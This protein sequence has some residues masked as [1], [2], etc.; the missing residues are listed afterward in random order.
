MGTCCNLH[1]LVGVAMDEVI[2]QG[3][4]SSLFE[5]EYGCGN[6]RIPSSQSAFLDIVI[7]LE[8]L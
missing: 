7:L 3:I 8:L 2:L 1:Y 5:S 4:L 6:A